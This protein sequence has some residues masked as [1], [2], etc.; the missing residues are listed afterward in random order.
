MLDLT[1]IYYSGVIIIA[2]VIVLIIL[3]IY[4]KKI[5][6]SQRDIPINDERVR[7][8]VEKSATIS[9]YI[10]LFTMSFF[11]I[12]LIIGVEFFKIVEPGSLNILTLEILIMALSFMILYK[13]YSKYGSI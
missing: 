3:A 9:F 11:L 12:S 10:G 5:N 1:I 8:I 13:Y 6:N 4:A 7:R 2:I